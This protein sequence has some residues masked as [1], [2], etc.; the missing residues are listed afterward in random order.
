MSAADPF[1]PGSTLLNFRLGERVSSSVWKAE[2]TRSGKKVAIKVLSRQLPKDPGKREALM[3]DVRLGAALYHSSL[4][5]IQ[6]ITAAGDALLLVTE[7]I[8]EQPIATRVRGKPLDR[9]EFFRV[10]YQIVDA[11][12]LLHAKNMVHGNVAGDSVLVTAAGQVKLCGLNLSNLL[13]RQGQPSAFQQKG[14]DPRAVAYMAPEQI[15]NQGVTPQTDI[16][17]IGLVLYEAATGRLAYQGANAAETARKV[18]EEQPPS[19]KSINPNVDNAVLGVMGRCLFKDPF[20]RHKDAKSMLEEIVRADPESQKFAAQIGKSGVAPAAVAPGQGQARNSILFLA[21]VANY[22]TLQATDQP[23]AAKAAARMQQILGEAVYLFDGEV[24]DPFGPRLV[25]ELPS[26]DQALE[27]ARKGEFDFSPEQQGANPIP[28][29]LLLHAGE[30]EVRDGKVSGAGVGK[31]FE[32]LQNLPPMQLHISEEFL[33]KGRGNLRL[34][35]SGARAGVKLYTIVPAEPTPAPEPEGEPEQEAEEL[36]AA[37]EAAAAEA[38]A[39]AAKKKRQMM[40]LAGAAALIVVLLGGAAVFLFSKPKATTTTAA[41]VVTAT[42]APAAAPRKILLQPFAVEGADPAMTD[43][44]NKVRLASIELMRAF[45]EVLIADSA[46]PDVTAFTATVRPGGTGPEIVTGSNAAPMTDSAAGIQ[47]VVQFVSEQLHLP[48]RAGSTPAAYN[49]FA[50]AVTARAANDVKKTETSLR[51]AIKAD[52]NF[53]PVEMFAM[54]FFTAQG[55]ENDAMTAARKVLAAA[56]E[57]VEA[58]RTVARISLKSG[59]L[60]S[61]FTSF[62]VILRKEPADIEALNVFGR[63]ACSANDTAKF[64]AVLRRLSAVPSVA[65]IHEP[66]LILATGKIDTAVEKYY[67]I[68]ERVQNNPALALKIG[69][70]AVLRHS[71]SIAEL[72][73]KKLQEI[74]PHYGLHILKAYLAAQGGSRA[75]ADSEL[76]A[77]LAASRPGDDYWTNVAEIA[78]IS[79]NGAGVLPALQHAADRKEPTASY[80]LSNPLFNFLLTDPEYQ[81]LREK[82]VAQ[83]NEVRTAL[84]GVSL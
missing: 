76:K 16:F 10:A 14:N 66:D 55:K 32:V 13:P 67:A 4:V 28:I 69:R 9:A 79:G 63:Y 80:V 61:T 78:V 60:A 33:K 44:A 70:I 19:P 12:K 50:D 5:N 73:L 25:A 17:S 39:S 52:P 64:N 3:R 62:A 40:F 59:D 43:R 81:K 54:R 51:A 84:A 37:E 74:D 36:G 48:Q 42:A 72:E 57:N 26:V 21:D 83:Q 31:A 11:I 45:P 53:L 6:E 65:S 30:V 47:S 68:E 18:V 7:W 38:L 82:F 24:L 41:A 56:P 71:A 49:A 27:A 20:R 46:A 2:D 29:R 15:A 1:S 58:A 77:A 75:D 35:D 22:A 23:A 8:E 34:R